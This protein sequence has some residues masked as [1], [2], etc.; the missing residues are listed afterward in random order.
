[1][2]PAATAPDTRQ[3]RLYAAQASLRALGVTV[4]TGQPANTGDAAAW[5]PATA[6]LTIAADLT[7]ADQLAVMVDMWTAIVTGP[8]A[9]RHATIG[10][11]LT[12]VADPAPASRR[13]R[14]LPTTVL[15]ALLPLALGAA[16]L[17][18]AP[19]VADVP[20]VWATTLQT[21]P[22]AHTGPAPRHRNLGQ[23]R[24]ITPIPVRARRRPIA[25]PDLRH[26]IATAAAT[27][28]D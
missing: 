14:P 24:W 27:D 10:R 12:A 11:H 22:A 13:K 19:T 6:T 18:P 16:C 23:R 5:D 3:T 4:T 25:T 28:D 7:P 2:T 20:T 9:T 26:I 15:G 1:M 21:A 17:Y 8:H